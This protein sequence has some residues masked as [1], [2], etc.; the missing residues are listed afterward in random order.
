MTTDISNGRL[1][2]I[3]DDFIELQVGQSRIRLEPNQA[4]MQA[5]TIEF[6]GAASG[7]NLSNS[8]VLK[9]SNPTVSKSSNPTISKSLN[10]AVSKPS[11]SS[12]SKFSNPTVSTPSNPSV[13]KPSNL[14]AE[15][16]FPGGCVPVEGVSENVVAQ[17]ETQ[18]LIGEAK[19][20]FNAVH[21]TA[22]NVEAAALS[23][24]SGASYDKTKDLLEKIDVVPV[25]KLKG[26]E[27]KLGA[28]VADVEMLA[29]GG[30][31]GI[32]SE[33]ILSP[34]EQLNAAL[35]ESKIYEQI[36]DVQ[37]SNPNASRALI[38]KLSRLERVQVFADKIE[39]TPEGA[40]RY[41]DKFR[42]ARTEGR[43]VGSRFV[44]Q[45]NPKTGDV[46]MWNEAYDTSGVVNRI[47]LKNINGIDINSSHFPP[48]LKDLLENENYTN[49]CLGNE[50]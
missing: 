5:K 46:T 36:N 18:T 47:H 20:A 32:W 11:N 45:F 21:F 15:L 2:L 4:I 12:V 42:P 9:S 28:V 29:V 30:V 6:K 33:E 26:D 35:H 40:I 44:T 10:P 34:E 41:F 24:I 19:E 17:A 23:G 37:A 49:S 48:T 43:T 38:N 7:S 14:P 22:V 13:S 31:W 50:L 1:S 25:E 16:C 27:Q 3:A 39:I 8:T